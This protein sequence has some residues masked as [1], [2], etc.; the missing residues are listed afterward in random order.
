[1]IVT[2][3]RGVMLLQGQHLMPQGDDL[4]V[5]VNLREAE[6]AQPVV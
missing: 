4:L 6:F 1:M 3:M 2:S 5:Y